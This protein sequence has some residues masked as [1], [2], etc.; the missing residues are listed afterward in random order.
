MQAHAPDPSVTLRA[1][2]P[3]QIA[4]AAPALAE[5]LLDGVAG[6]AQ[7]SFMDDLT[8]AR[9]E[10]FWRGVAEAAASDGRVLLVAE[11]DQGLVGTVQLVPAWADNQ[12]HRADIAKM[13]VHSRGRNRG[14]GAR[15]L[16]AAETAARAMG[17]TL[18][19][20]DTVTGEA[21][22]RLYARLGWTAVGVIPNYALY[23]DGRPGDCTFFYK[24]L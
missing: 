14:V 17:K 19:T 21:G 10:A 20:L 11:D 3:A 24:A 7:I 15:L 5:I 1:L 16:T 12:P 4:E 6:G 22:E 23:P 2:S 9:A 18:L 8:P 13:L